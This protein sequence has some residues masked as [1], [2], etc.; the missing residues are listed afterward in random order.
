M[1]ISSNSGIRPGAGRLQAKATVKPINF[2]CLAPT[3][4]QVVLVGDF[5]QWNPTSHPLKKQV[6]GSWQ[7][8]VSLSHGSH[9]YQFLVDGTPTNDPRAQGITRNERGERVS[10]LMVS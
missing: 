5:N 9:L 8:A 1:T 4:Q 7:L 2:L 6:D 10:M 3:A